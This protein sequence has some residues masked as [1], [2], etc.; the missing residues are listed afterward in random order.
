MPQT[1][2]HPNGWNTHI[3]YCNLGG[4]CGQSCP[5]CRAEVYLKNIDKDA[6]IGACP[7]CIKKT[8]N[9]LKYKKQNY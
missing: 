6:Y 5:C 1:P 9:S 2:S 8:H 4:Q 3:H 7:I